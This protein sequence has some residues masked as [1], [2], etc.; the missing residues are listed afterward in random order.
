MVKIQNKGDQSVTMLNDHL[1]LEDYDD[2][3]K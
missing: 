3:I 1:T 2:A